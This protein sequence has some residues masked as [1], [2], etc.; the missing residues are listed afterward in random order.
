MKAIQAIQKWQK[1]IDSKTVENSRIVAD[2][3]RYD[4]IYIKGKP[5]VIATCWMKEDEELSLSKAVKRIE[6]AAT[7]SSRNPQRPLER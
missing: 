7:R 1:W 6:A 4:L 2:N 3:I 5:R